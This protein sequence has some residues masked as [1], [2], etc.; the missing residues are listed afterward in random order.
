MVF[1]DESKFNTFG[2]LDGRQYCWSKKRE[3]LL[4]HHVQ[5]IV[6]IG[7]WKHYDLGMYDLGGS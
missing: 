7:G 1:Q 2:C 3:Y 4:G 6:K 5:A